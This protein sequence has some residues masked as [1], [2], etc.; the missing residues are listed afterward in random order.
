MKLS[1]RRR[2]L[3]SNL[4]TLAFVAVIGGIGFQAVR[5]VSA[6]MD[7]VG[8]N[9]VAMKNQLQADMMHDALRGDVLAALL[10]ADPVQAAQAVKDADE[11]IG[12]FRARL[13][14]MDKNTA[15]AGLR[16]AM[17]KVRPD[18]DAYIASAAALVTKAGGDKEAAQAQ[19]APFMQHF[20]KLEASMGD[21]SEL[22]ETNS[23]QAAQAAN[24][25]VGQSRNMIIGV[26]LLSMLVA[27][28]LGY[29]NARAIVAPLNAAIASAT[30]IASGDLSETGEQRV[31]PAQ[32]DLTETGRL[33]EALSGMRANLHRIVSRVRQGTDAIATSSGQIA[34][35][36]LDLS[37]RTESQASSLEETAAS[38]EELTSTVRQNA[39]NARQAT[40]LATS[41]ADVAG[42]GGA[43]VAS[44]VRTMGAID[45]ASR[46]IGEIIGVIGA[47]AGHVALG[48][49]L[50]GDAGATMD[51]IVASVQRV[52]DIMSEISIASGE[53]ESGIG[54]VNQAIGEIDGLTQQNAALVEQA[55]AAAASMQEQA[56]ELAGIV[57]VFRLEASRDAGTARLLR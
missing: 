56:G 11:H 42:K 44:V 51:D 31:D 39:D 16:Q 26:S 27:L 54:Q 25:V 28:V 55:A 21:L 49:K 3:L 40:V 29:L 30:R 18:A 41:A 20:R 37:A 50:V 36:N 2:L 46:Q 13:A 5:T 15:D 10:A 45:D 14:E 47:S 19:F 48:S 17:A 6:A 43:V 1:I 32:P 8:A 7:A 9:G 38:M 12:L 57:D 53:Q 33:I 22:I 35:G 34:A 23:E 24:G 4:A 52:N